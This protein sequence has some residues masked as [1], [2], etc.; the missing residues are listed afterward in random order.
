ML[1]A[2][3]TKKRLDGKIQ[4]YEQG[5]P[6]NQFREKMITLHNSNYFGGERDRTGTRVVG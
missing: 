2:L 4:S 6:R 5:L 3:A 1:E